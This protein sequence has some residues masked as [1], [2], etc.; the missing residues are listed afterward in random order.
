MKIND[1]KSHTLFWIQKYNCRGYN[2]N[3]ECISAKRCTYTWACVCVC[4]CACAY[5]LVCVYS[6]NLIDFRKNYKKNKVMK[7]SKAVK[8]NAIFILFDY[9]YTIAHQLMYVN[10][11]YF[12]IICCCC[13]YFVVV[14]FLINLCADCVFSPINPEH[15]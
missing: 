5:R 1:I 13:C 6:P 11:F 7:L 2:A 4:G 14:I 15:F 10:V 12:H 3:D 9:L 8:R